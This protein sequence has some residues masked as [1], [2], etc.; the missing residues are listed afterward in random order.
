[1][2][3]YFK[4][5]FICIYFNCQIVVADSVDKKSV[6]L[7]TRFES[8]SVMPLQQP[9]ASESVLFFC[10][11]VDYDSARPTFCPQEFVTCDLQETKFLCLFGLTDLH[12]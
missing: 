2:H 1:V 4:A 5:Q 11:S 9:L 6:R 7:N 3:W 8:L 10:G 12:Y